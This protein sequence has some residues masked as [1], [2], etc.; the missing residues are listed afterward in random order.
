MSIPGVSRDKSDEKEPQPLIFH[1]HGRFAEMMADTAQSSVFIRQ[2][3]AQTDTP[4]MPTHRTPSLVSFVGQ[5]GMGKSS[6]IKFLILLRT[7]VG[8]GPPHCPVAG[9]PGSDLPTSE[10]V[11]LYLDPTTFFSEA[12]I[13]YADSEGLGGGERHPLATASRA[14]R[15][16]L[17]ANETSDDDSISFQTRFSSRREI[18]WAKTAEQRTR[19]FAASRFYPRL[20]F[21][22]SDAVVFVHKNSRYFSE[23]G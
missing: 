19:S 16:S 8:V 4:A 23:I 2:M 3:M 21:T 5:S 13:L 22:F 14:R 17:L 6:L 20:L 18:Q 7:P 1:D 15:D 10:D 9:K 11:H 12:P